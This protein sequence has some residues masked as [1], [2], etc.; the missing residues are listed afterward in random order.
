[1]KQGLENDQSSNNRESIPVFASPMTLVDGRACFRYLIQGSSHG[2]IRETCG[3]TLRSR[4]ETRALQALILDR[5]LVAQRP[6]NFSV[7]LGQVE[8]DLR[9]DSS[10]QHHLG[11]FVSRHPSAVKLGSPY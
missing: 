9:F 1:M 2:L 10:E 7:S 11:R 6:S 5:C 8:Y 4:V 3:P